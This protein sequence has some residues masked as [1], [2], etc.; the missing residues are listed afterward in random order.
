MSIEVRLVRN[1]LLS[2]LGKLINNLFPGCEYRF[3]KHKFPFTN[4]SYEAEVNYGG[5]WLEILGCGIV[6]STIMGNCGLSVGEKVAWAFGLGLE[7]L[8]MILYSIPDIRLFWSDSPKFLQ[9]WEG[10]DITSDVKFKPF[11]DFES[12]IHSVS[13]WLPHNKEFV[14]N[15]FYEFV[16]A[17]T[18]NLVS[19]IKRFDVFIH[20]KT[21]RV[22]HAYHLVFEPI[23][24]LVNVNNPADYTARVLEVYKN[25]LVRLRT[26]MGLELR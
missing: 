24:E 22:S 2:T 6:H 20:R 1:K 15:D 13:F 4:P 11:S 5:S 19:E 8:A 3:Y 26:E 14:E 12:V 9:Q 21:G 18:D 25:L 7:R 10:R 17:C 16:R 23:G